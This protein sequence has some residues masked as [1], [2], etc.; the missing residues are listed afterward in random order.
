M[1]VYTRV[2]AI[3]FLCKVNKFLRNPSPN[4]Q[5]VRR[6]SLDDIIYIYIYSIT[7]YQIRTSTCHAI[8]NFNFFY[9]RQI[10]SKLFTRFLF[11]LATAATAPLAPETIGYFSLLSAEKVAECGTRGKKMIK[12]GS[13]STIYVLYRLMYVYI[14]NIHLY[15]EKLFVHAHIYIYIY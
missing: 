13:V 4:G 2:S 3:L 10:A 15:R 6:S 12:L 5:S 8:N 11:S 9:S 1:L 14:N 7:Y